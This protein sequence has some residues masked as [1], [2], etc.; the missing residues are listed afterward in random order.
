LNLLSIF[1]FFLSK[2]NKNKNKK[3]K[4]KSKSKYR[5]DENIP[6]MGTRR[7][8]TELKYQNS[9]LNWHS[10]EIF[11]HNT[12][13]VNVDYDVA[14]KCRRTKSFPFFMIL[15]IIAQLITFA[16]S[17]YYNNK[18]FN[19]PIEMDPF[20]PSVGP[21][22]ITLIQ[23]G[24]KYTP[25]ITE[26]DYFNPPTCP[27]GSKESYPPQFLER[28]DEFI[29]CGDLERYCGM[30]GNLGQWWRYI[31]PIFLNNGAVPLFVNLL[32]EIFIAIPLERG[33]G[34]FRMALIFLSSGIFGYVVSASF[35]VQMRTF[36]FLFFL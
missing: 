8:E 31:V 24:A 5:V 21:F 19:S 27:P 10:T 17:L 20:N 36:L 2:K 30:G 22:N 4:T 14:Q 26:T 6:L 15:F 33:I 35:Y 7:G 3:Q 11:E 34:S 1:S 25:C 12:L 32:A 23:L 18:E 29:A 28:F 9:I 13:V 16:Y